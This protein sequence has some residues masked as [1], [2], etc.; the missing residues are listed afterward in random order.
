VHAPATLLRL[1][2]GVYSPASGAF[3]RLPEDGGWP[4]FLDDGETVVYLRAALDAIRAWNRGTGRTWTV[5]VPPEGQ[6]FRYL[7]LSA[8]QRHLFTVR[9]TSEGDVWLLG[10][11]DP[12][13]GNS[14]A[15]SHTSL[16]G[17]GT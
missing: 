17:G 3:V 13:P 6:V 4:V 15:P 14:G 2:M 8:D 12:A 1:G 7:S 10:S 5:A 16:R 11:Q 9:G